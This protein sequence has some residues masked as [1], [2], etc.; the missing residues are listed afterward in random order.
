[1]F[2]I[3]HPFVSLLGLILMA[4]GLFMGYIIERSNIEKGVTPPRWVNAILHVAM[5]TFLAFP[6][7]GLPVSTALNQ[8]LG[9]RGWNL[10]LIVLFLA[11]IGYVAGIKKA[12]STKK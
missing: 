11:A 10:F 7:F 12:R 2:T 9:I 5:F 6:A 1:M 8:H 3:E 4:S